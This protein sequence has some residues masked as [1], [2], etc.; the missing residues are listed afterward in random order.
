MSSS[1]L[2]T[3]KQSL[4]DA[5]FEIYRTQPSEIQVAER[6]RLHIMDS[7]IRIRLGESFDV[8]FTARSQKS[9]F[10]SVGADELFDKVRGTIGHA[11]QERGYREEG[12]QTVEVKDPMDDAKVLDTWHE[13]TYA[14]SADDVEGV[15]DE[16]RW[17]LGVD[18]YVSP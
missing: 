9:D 5:G 16:V 3:V 1:D 11:A 2:Q 14:K 4:L 6:V 7:G 12:S 18:K 13:V 8:V 15:V 10:P 17:A